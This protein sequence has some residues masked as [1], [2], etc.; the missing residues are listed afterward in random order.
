M[1]GDLKKLIKTLIDKYA[2]PKLIEKELLLIFQIMKF[3]KV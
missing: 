3:L 2:D 1:D